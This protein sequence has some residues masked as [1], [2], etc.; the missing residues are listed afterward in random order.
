V[1]CFIVW[2]AIQY[3]GYE[4][5]DAARRMIFGGIFRRVLV[6]KL[7]IR[8]L[9]TAVEL[10]NTLDECWSALLDASRCFGFS[11]VSLEFNGRPRIARLVDIE[12]AD[13]WDMRIPLNHSG[14]VHLRVP[15]HSVQ[16][17]VII[18]RLVT[19]LGTVFADK[20]AAVTVHPPAPCNYKK[21]SKDLHDVI[22]PDL[23]RLA[24]A[25]TSTQTVLPVEA[26]LSA[27]SGM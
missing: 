3:L 1:F 4:E 24:I 7:Y 20:L 13:C 25:L 23:E 19:A 21:A 12:Y 14:H 16:P 15:L 10:A 6:G 18:G 9:E 22:E 17:P 11:E 5:F 27:A 26:D 8:Q 2:F